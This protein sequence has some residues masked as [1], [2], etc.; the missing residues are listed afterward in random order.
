MKQ[1]IKATETPRPKRLWRGGQ[2]S[3]RS[4]RTVS[5]EVFGDKPERSPSMSVS[6]GDEF[7][8]VNWRVR[9]IHQ[10]FCL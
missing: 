10:H 9:K 5:S 4:G 7:P 8:G 6:L 1:R 2:T 3:S